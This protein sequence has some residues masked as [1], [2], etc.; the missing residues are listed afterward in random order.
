M[1]RPTARSRG[2]AALDLGDQPET[3]PTVLKQKPKVFPLPLW[4]SIRYTTV[5]KVEDPFVLKG[6]WTG[7][8]EYTR[9]VLEALAPWEGQEH[10]SHAEALWCWQQGAAAYAL[11]PVLDLHEVN[12]LK[13]FA[14]PD[15]LCRCLL[16]PQVHNLLEPQT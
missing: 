3:E 15:E 12:L 13:N 2:L 9:E 6:I 10:V 11:D 16:E 4:P 5:F 14:S 1:S 7:S 8:A